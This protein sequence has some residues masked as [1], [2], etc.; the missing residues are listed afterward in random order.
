MGLWGAAQAIAAGFGGL[1]GAAGVDALRLVLTDAAAFG[2]VFAA[3]GFL[4]LAAAAMAA[5]TI[6]PRPA[7]PSLVPG[8]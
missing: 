3:E 7:S 8:E 1:A 6:R 2:C 4:F 5:R